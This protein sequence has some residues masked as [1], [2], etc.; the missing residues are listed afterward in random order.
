MSK[1]LACGCILTNDN[2]GRW[3]PRFCEACDKKRMAHLARRFREIE[4]ALGK[5]EADETVNSNPAEFPRH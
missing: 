5:E 2:R 4:K 1:C 3:G